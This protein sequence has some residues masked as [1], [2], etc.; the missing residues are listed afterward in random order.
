MANT[1]MQ[2]S[3]HRVGKAGVFLLRFCSALLQIVNLFDI[4]SNS[5]TPYA[6]PFCILE[7]PY[8]KLLAMITELFFCFPQFFKIISLLRLHFRQFLSPDLIIIYGLSPILGKMTYVVK[9]ATLK[10]IQ[11]F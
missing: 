3:P 2:Y 11:S 1:T 7:V 4:N 9:A 10:V 5:R 6:I 8:S